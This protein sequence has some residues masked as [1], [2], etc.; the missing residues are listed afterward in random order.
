[1]IGT[2]LARSV[3]QDGAYE[4]GIN[5]EW[6][7]VSRCRRRYGTS[8]VK[9]NDG[10]PHTVVGVREYNDIVKVYVDGQLAASDYKSETKDFH[11]ELPAANIMLGCRAVLLIRRPTR[12]PRRS[13]I[14]PS[15]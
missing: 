14:A 5:A 1:M 15:V 10:K 8:K 13:S 7:V 12:P 6:H 2:D 11:H 3:S 4:L 9:V